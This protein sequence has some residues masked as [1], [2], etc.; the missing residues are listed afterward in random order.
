MAHL[1]GPTQPTGLDKITYAVHTRGLRLVKCGLLLGFAVR[2]KDL[3]LVRRCFS[4]GNG[5]TSHPA[6][7]AATSDCEEHLNA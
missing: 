4:S 5:K 2:G 3:G 6:T 7:M 1:T